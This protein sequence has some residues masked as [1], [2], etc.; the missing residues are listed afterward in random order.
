MRATVSVSPQFVLLDVSVPD[1][2][3]FEVASR[4]RADGVVSTI[5]FTSSCDRTDFGSLVPIRV[6]RA[7]LPKDERSG[8]ALGAFAA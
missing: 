7:S 1:V 2:D 6:V 5:V 8:D 4:L 3:G